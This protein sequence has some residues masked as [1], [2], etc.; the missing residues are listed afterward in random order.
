[1]AVWFWYWLIYSLLG[2]G[3]EKGFAA[4]THAEKQNRKGF[5]L[6]PLCPVYGL[7]MAAVLALRPLVGQGLGLF[8]AGGL[9]ATA[10]EYGVHWAYDRLLGVRFWDYTGIRGNLAGRVCLPFSLAWGLLAL[11]MARLIQP[12]LELWAPRIPP[13]L[14]WVMLLVVTA[15]AVCSVR[16]LQ[17]TGDPEKLRLSALG[18]AA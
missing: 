13:L 1:M 14:T 6:L 9:A 18:R 11:A 8:L 2:Y 16:L 15:D 3:L 17:L 5:L 7:G 10:V 12:L 4:A